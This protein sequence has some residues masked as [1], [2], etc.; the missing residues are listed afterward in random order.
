MSPVYNRSIHRVEL[1]ITGISCA[2]VTIH[3]VKSYSSR[4]ANPIKH[5]STPENIL[6]YNI[7]INICQITMLM[8]YD[9]V[10]S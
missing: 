4:E 7:G 10:D 3:S 9:F 2:P 1:E 5:L 6:T 8:L